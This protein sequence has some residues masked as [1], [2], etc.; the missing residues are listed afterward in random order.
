MDLNK[1][2][3]LYCNIHKPTRSKKMIEHGTPKLFAWL[4]TRGMKRLERWKKLKF[5]IFKAWL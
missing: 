1:D 4:F 2:I 5:S 3:L